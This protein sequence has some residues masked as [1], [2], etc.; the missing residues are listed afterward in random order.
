M[1]LAR[2]KK[3][4]VLLHLSAMSCKTRGRMEGWRDQPPTTSTINQPVALQS[5]K[6]KRASVKKKSVKKKE[7]KKG[8]DKL[9]VVQK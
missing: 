6:S 9:I 3:S 4:L 5:S 7:K 2:D 8:K 1:S